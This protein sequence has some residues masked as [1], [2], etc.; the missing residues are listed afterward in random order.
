MG[1]CGFWTNL[2]I[3]AL[4]ELSKYISTNKHLSD[5]PKEIEL[6]ENGIDFSEMQKIQMQKIEELVLY[7]FVSFSVIYINWA[8]CQG[9]FNTKFFF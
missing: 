3:D 4:N 2:W 7:V 9:S 5:V 8:N 1:W 6:K